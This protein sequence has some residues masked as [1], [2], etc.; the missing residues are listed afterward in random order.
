LQQI[1]FRLKGIL[2]PAAGIGKKSP[3]CKRSRWGIGRKKKN[4][5]NANFR[6]FAASLW[7]PELL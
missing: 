1:V 7:I 4:G 6:R 5:G 3:G 2:N